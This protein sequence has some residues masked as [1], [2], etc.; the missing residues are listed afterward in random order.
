MT[1]LTANEFANEFANG[2]AN[3]I[4]N[5][6]AND[7]ANVIANVIANAGIDMDPC[8]LVDAENIFLRI[9][10]SSLKI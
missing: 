2:I 9:W 10:T 3:D 4:A 6:I 1:E 5:I 8:S 7:F